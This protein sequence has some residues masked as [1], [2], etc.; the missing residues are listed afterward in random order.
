MRH[1]L[2][3]ALVQKGQVQPIDSFLSDSTVHDA[4]FVRG[5]AAISQLVAAN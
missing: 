2:L 3:G 5:A 4:D 1:R